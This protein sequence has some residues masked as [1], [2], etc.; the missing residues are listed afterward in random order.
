MVW[1]AC[2][3]TFTCMSLYICFICF[4]KSPCERTKM[5]ASI[6][7][8]RL[9]WVTVF[10]IFKP[11]IRHWVPVAA[12]GRRWKRSD[13]ET[14]REIKS[15]RERAEEISNF[16]WSHFPHMYIIYMCTYTNHVSQRKYTAHSDTSFIPLLHFYYSFSLYMCTT[17]VCECECVDLWIKYVLILYNVCAFSHIKCACVCVFQVCVFFWKANRETS[18]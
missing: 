7:R 15:E 12:T 10:L 14:D 8:M 17:R 13:F 9:F 3:H 5:S 1:I 16:W 18:K 6:M 11:K 4:N 2:V